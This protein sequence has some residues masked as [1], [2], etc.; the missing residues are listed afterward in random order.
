MSEM[1]YVIRYDMKPRSYFSR[2]TGIGP[3]FGASL[4]DTP[5]YDNLADA[6]MILRRFKTVAAA[7]CEVVAVKRSVRK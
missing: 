2:M 5:R 7:V 1:Q 6:D 4:R 3:M